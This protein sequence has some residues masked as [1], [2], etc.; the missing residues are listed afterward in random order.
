MLTKSKVL[1]NTGLD[2][3]GSKVLVNNNINLN[4]TQTGNSSSL[5]NG[6]LKPK[7]A[8]ITREVDGITIINPTENPYDKIE[9]LE[10][11]Q[12]NEDEAPNSSKVKYE[13]KVSELDLLKRI[14]R[15]YLT[16][17]MRIDGKLVLKSDDIIDLIK[18]ITFAD[19]VNINVDYEINCCGKSKGLNSIS[20]ILII[21]NGATVDMK[22]KFNEEYNSLLNYGISL[23]FSFD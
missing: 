18:F 9:Q 21:K 16:N 22:Y 20:K 19:E 17:I 15:L 13:E 2:L 10:A 1:S 4:T 11:Q 8:T 14:L 6:K 7:A 5:S 3:S 23:D 12:A